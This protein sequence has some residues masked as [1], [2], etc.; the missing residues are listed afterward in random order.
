LFGGTL[1]DHQDRH[2]LER[3]LELEMSNA[4]ALADLQ[5]SV[6][7][8]QAAQGNVP[9]D[10]SAGVETAAS[11]INAVTTSLGGTPPAAT[12]AAATPAA[13]AVEAPATPSAPDP[14]PPAPDPNP[15]ETA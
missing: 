12:P 10:I 13:P 5:A 7:A 11:D 6:A 4:S 2:L 8:L 15:P 3:I 14:N 1:F 9:Q